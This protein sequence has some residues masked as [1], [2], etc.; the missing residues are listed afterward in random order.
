MKIAALLGLIIGLILV[1]IN[2]YYELSS[3]KS[4]QQAEEVEANFDSDFQNIFKH[5]D[6]ISEVSSLDHE[7]ANFRL[8]MQ[9][10]KVTVSF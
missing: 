10:F 6:F 2:V 1:S 7:T 4:F 3:P 5:S 8:Q 9:Q